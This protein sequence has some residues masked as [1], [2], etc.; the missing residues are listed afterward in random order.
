MPITQQWRGSD[1]I[2]V[3]DGI[4]LRNVADEDGAV[5]V[6]YLN[7]RSQ[8]PRNDL[9]GQAGVHVLNEETNLEIVLRFPP[10]AT[11][12]L[13]L[14]Q[15]YFD[16]RRQIIRMTG[17][18]VGSDTSGYVARN[19]VVSDTGTWGGGKNPEMFEFTF[20][21]ISGVIRYGGQRIIPG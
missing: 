18:N 1:L 14:L 8:T 11:A 5:T 20:H 6:R 3:I 12:D 9:T 13:A 19:V 17:K 15:S 2:N 21:A 10:G 4:P 16:T 7:A